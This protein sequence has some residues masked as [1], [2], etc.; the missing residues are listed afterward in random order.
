MSTDP[1]VEQI[2]TAV[3][4]L[5]EVAG[6][7]PATRRLLNA[8]FRDVHSLK[9]IAAANGLNSLVAAAHESENVLHSIRT[10]TATTDA[11]VSNAIPA[12][13]WNSLKQEQKHT[14]R[15]SI[16]EG[17]S[18]FLVQT[19]FEVA[20]VDRQ[21]KGLKETLSKT[22]EVISTL[23]TIDKERLGKISFRMLYART[24]A[25]DRTLPDLSNMSDVTVEE[26]SPPV[27]AT[28]PQDMNELK[29]LE[30]SFE[31]L[32]AE[33]INSGI[34]PF[35]DVFQQALR[36]GRSASVA[37]SKEVD[38]EVRGQDLVPETLCEVI[39]NPL[40]HLV[41]NAVDHGIEAGNERIRLG[42]SPRGK[43]V[44]EVT[45]SEAYTTI[46]VTDDGRG[47]DP[48]LIPT[49][50]HPGYSTASELSAISGRGVGLDA[51]KTQI[52]EAGGSVSVSSELGKGSTFKLTLP[53]SE[54][55]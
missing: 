54:C 26:I 15:Q 5:R 7:G 36:A 14:L 38:F 1:K 22:G 19:S 13:I 21:F 50:F 48:A 9:A 24:A 47:I 51:V 32:S 40:V 46:T 43:I 49:I 27:H 16:A 10:G 52:E 44:I 55:T 39:A 29:A 33:L 12:D 18:L 35:D 23:A 3:E 20:D 45:T 17:A 41:R 53:N 37:T 11:F 28:A 2:L 30:R 25:G 42:K 8:L 6:D 4:K 34:A 31:K